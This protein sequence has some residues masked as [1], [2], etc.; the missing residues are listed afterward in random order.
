MGIPSGP[1]WDK[2][3]PPTLHVGNESVVKYMEEARNS[4]LCVFGRHPNS[5]GL[6]GGGEFPF[7][8][9]GENIDTRRLQNQCE[10]IH[11]GTNSRNSTPWFPFGFQRRFGKSG[12][13]QVEISEE[14][15]G[16][17]SNQQKVDPKEK[18]GNSRGHKEFFGGNAIFESLHRP[19]SALSESK[20]FERLG[21]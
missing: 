1:I 18:C 21:Q 16:K 19:I 6:G 2:Y 14:G 4:S 3:H 10:K 17:T 13:P 20:H 7:L 8:S 15:V 5:G 11:F 9:G 12:S